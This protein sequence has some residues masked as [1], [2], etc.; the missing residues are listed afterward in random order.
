M[1]HLNDPAP[2]LVLVDGF[3]LYLCILLLLQLAMIKNA[4]N[5]Q[6]ELHKNEANECRSTIIIILVE[7]DFSFSFLLCSG[8]GTS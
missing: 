4:G 7:D 8:T 5:F 3:C 6:E 1:V 2:M